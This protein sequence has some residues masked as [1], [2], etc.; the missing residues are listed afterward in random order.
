MNGPIQNQ[1]SSIMLGN[2]ED[3]LNGYPWGKEGE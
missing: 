2:K 3:D 1:R